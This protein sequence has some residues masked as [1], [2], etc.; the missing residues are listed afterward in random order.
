L[1]RSRPTA[2]SLRV[3]NTLRPVDILPTQNHANVY[4][5]EWKSVIV[6]DLSCQGADPG[7]ARA[8]QADDC[9]FSPPRRAPGRPRLFPCAGTCCPA[10]RGHHASRPLWRPPMFERG[11]RDGGRGGAT[12]DV[13][14]RA[15][16]RATA[17]GSVLRDARVGTWQRRAR[18]GLALLRERRGRDRAQEHVGGD[19]RGIYALN[20]VWGEGTAAGASWPAHGDGRAAASA[21]RP[22]A[23][24]PRGRGSLLD[25]GAGCGQTPPQARRSCGVTPHR[26]VQAWP[27]A[28]RSAVAGCRRPRDAV[29]ALF[30]LLSDLRFGPLF[31][32]YAPPYFPT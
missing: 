17:C 3:A 9:R 13:S 8:C 32:Q 31:L 23:L 12:P 27:S 20:V 19:E 5:T 10:V 24:G 21:R 7:P 11:A 29:G 15:A 26:R 6:K 2:R 16:D 28:G 30:L 22:V 18:R 14:R 1:L 25:A 4:F